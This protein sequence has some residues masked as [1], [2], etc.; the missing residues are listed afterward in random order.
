MLSS[1]FHKRALKA[2]HAGAGGA[3]DTVRRC[4]NETYKRTAAWPRAWPEALG[5]RGRAAR[6]DRA[7]GA[8]SAH[9][10]ASLRGRGAPRAGHDGGG[11]P[12]RETGGRRA[13]PTPPP[14]ARSRRPKAK[15]EPRL[16]P[17]GAPPHPGAPAPPAR[18]AGRRLTLCSRLLLCAAILE[19]P[20]R[21][22]PPPGRAG[23]SG[24]RLERPGAGAEAR[25]AGERAR[26]ATWRPARAGRRGACAQAQSPSARSCVSW[27]LTRRLA[28]VIAPRASSFVSFPRDAFQGGRPKPPE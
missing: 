15:R 18:G 22:R 11:E 20:P 5:A 10:H 4:R 23:E 6:A 25:A 12:A 27:A 9:A 14:P 28:H 16:H 7:G 1:L 17:T 8:R 24:G 26:S 21:A 3:G 13:P 2:G 19:G